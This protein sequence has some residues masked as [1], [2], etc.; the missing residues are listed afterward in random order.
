MSLKTL[1][2]SKGIEKVAEKVEPGKLLSFIKYLHNRYFE[3]KAV[4][5]SGYKTKMREKFENV[6]NEVLGTSQRNLNDIY[7]PQSIVDESSMTEVVVD[8]CPIDLLRKYKNIVIRDY[9]GRGKSTILKKMFIGAVDKGLFPLFVEL[10]NIKEGSSLIDELLSDLSVI[11]DAFSERL[12]KSLLKHEEF[13]IML[14]GFDEVD[15]TIR[16]NVVKDINKLILRGNNNLVVLTSR[17]D[18]AIVGFNNF[19]SYSIKDFS[20]EQACDLIAKYDNN[21]YGS[22]QLISEIKDGRHNNVFEFFKSPLHTALFYNV[23]VGKR[24][25]PY[26]LYEVCSEIF[27]SLYNLH[28]LSKDGYFE[29]KKKC[30]LSEG[31]YTKV[32]GY[33]AFWCLKKHKN[34][35]HNSEI[36]ILFDGIRMQYPSISFVNEDLKIDIIVGLSLFKM[37]GNEMC[38]IHETMLYYFAACYI[39]LDNVENRKNLF[40]SFYR[41]NNLKDY[42]QMLVMYSELEPVEF[43]KYFLTQLLD[44]MQQQYNQLLKFFHRN[45]S[46]DSFHARSYFMFMKEIIIEKEGAD[47][48]INTVGKSKEFAMDIL[49]HMYLDKYSSLNTLLY[50]PYIVVDAKMKKRIGI[51]SYDETQDMY[52]YVNSLVA[53]QIGKGEYYLSLEMICL[54]KEILNNEL[55]I[56]EDVNLLHNI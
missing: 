41:S 46:Y 35:I 45:V 4:L 27:H 2:V 31:D 30:N 18:D 55:L 51:N 29:H 8:T 33:I 13:I 37:Q 12:L 28:D 10:R 43:R 21:G 50:H 19:R 14:D 36:S 23:F 9:A 11:S 7:V 48:I 15:S 16:E 34:R 54:I 52:D 26:K 17:N 40:R 6:S 44:D 32:L 22:H 25:V 38:W 53:K 42:E 1:L 24:S 56:T 49:F 47:V 39:R 20:I 3:N 5:F